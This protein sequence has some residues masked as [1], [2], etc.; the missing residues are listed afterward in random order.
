M[1]ARLSHERAPLNLLSLTHPTYRI[2]AAQHAAARGSDEGACEGAPLLSSRQPLES[3]R[4]EQNPV[5]ASAA[6]TVPPREAAT[7]VP[8]PPSALCVA[9]E[10][11]RVAHVIV[12]RRA[13]RVGLQL[14]DEL[15]GDAPAIV[16]EL[17]RLLPSEAQPRPRRPLGNATSAPMISTIA[18]VRRP[19]DR[20]SISRR[21]VASG[22]APSCNAEATISRLERTGRS[23]LST[24]VAV[25]FSSPT[26]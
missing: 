18:T 21:T 14:P 11:R 17:R 20:R 24:F 3:A 25:S 8:A 26:L 2:H 12:S 9:F 22:Q 4:M 16:A 19:S 15:L 6:S 5:A 13:L 1:S 7:A 23:S 10:L